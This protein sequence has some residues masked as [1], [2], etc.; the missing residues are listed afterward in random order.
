M[1]F[2]L[3]Y[4]FAFCLGSQGTL[5]H[6]CQNEGAHKALLNWL[7][8]LKKKGPALQRR[9]ELPNTFSDT[10][11]IIYVCKAHLHETWFSY[12]CMYREMSYNTF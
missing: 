11:F 8:N 12:V 6:L 10:G 4:I 7:S 2:G 5:L 9:P 1:R 3:K